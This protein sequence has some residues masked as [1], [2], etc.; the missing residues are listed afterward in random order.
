VQAAA[1]LAVVA[2]ALSAG[3]AA[4]MALMRAPLYL[5]V[6][7]A[8]GGIR[9]IARLA[10]PRRSSVVVAALDDGPRLQEKG[11]ASLIRD[12]SKAGQAM[13]DLGMRL[14]EKRFEGSALA[15]QVRV[16]VDGLQ[17]PSGVEVGATAYSSPQEFEAALLAAMREAHDASQDAIRGDVWRLYRDNPSLLQ[18]PLG[19][20]GIGDAAEDLYRQHDSAVE[21]TEDT[22]RLAAE[23]FTEFDEDKDGYWNL[24]EASR[25]QMATEGTNLSQDAFEALIIG[26]APRGGRDLTEEELEKGLPRAQVEALYTNVELQRSLGVALDVRRDY[27]TVFGNRADGGIVE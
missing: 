22:L 7:V 17:R 3:T 20:V 25:A 16:S 15:G 21:Q 18:A 1:T 19:E 11:L 27:A 12:Q 10:T 2:L 14:R 23:L 26:A 8:P 5:F 4:A 13:K 6:G 9:R 24:N